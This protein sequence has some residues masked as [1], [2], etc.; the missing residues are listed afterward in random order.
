M[1]IF[2]YAPDRHLRRFPVDDAGAWWPRGVSMPAAVAR[3]YWH[4]DDWQDRFKGYPPFLPIGD[5]AQH[6]LSHLAWSERANAVLQDMRGIQAS[7]KADFDG[8][9]LHVVQPMLLEHAIDVAAC[10]VLTDQEDRPF[11]LKRHAFREDQVTLDV[12]WAGLM[13]FPEIYLSERFVDTC[14]AAG[15]VG[16]AGLRLV[17][18]DGP[19]GPRFAP[20]AD[21]DP[22]WIDRPGVVQEYRLLM[23]RAHWRAAD[24]HAGMDA[25]QD[26]TL[27]LMREG[28]LPC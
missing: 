3:A 28:W 7:A 27:L 19:V 15:L 26:A 22:L 21:P 12:F 8:T 11:A 25:A 16:T 23:R 18:D 2:R 13:P 1:K 24:Y 20:V 14:H 6:T 4:S 9:T 17:W 5:L 10:E